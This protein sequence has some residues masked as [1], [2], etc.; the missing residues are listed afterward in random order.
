MTRFSITVFWQDEDEKAI[1]D[2][3]QIKLTDEC[4][5]MGGRITKTEEGQNWGKTSFVLPGSEKRFA[6]V[7]EGTWIAL[8][9]LGIRAKLENPLALD[10]LK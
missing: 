9:S 7:L 3:T 2:S 8:S 4:K 1:G 10:R 5:S 6:N